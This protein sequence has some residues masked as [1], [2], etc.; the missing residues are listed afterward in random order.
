MQQV[1]VTG[2]TGFV[3]SHC[4]L[5]LLQQ[6]YA[7]KTSI[8]TP[9]KKNK[10]LEMLRTGGISDFQHIQ[11]II[12]DLTADQY[13][14]DAAAGCEYVLHVASPIYLRVPKDPEEMI[15]PAVDG[16]LRVLKAARDAG[17]KRVV[18]TSNFGAV[19]YSHRDPAT[20]ITEK[21]YTDPDEK[22]LSAYNKSKVMSEKAA[23]QFIREQGHGL[24]FCTVN[25]MGIFGPSLGPD[26]S[27]GFELLRNIINGEMKA[28]PNMDLGIVDVRD[29]ADLHIRAMTS[30]KANGERFLA[31]AGGTMSL[32]E[33]AGFIKKHL[34]AIGA[35]ISTKSLADWKVKLAAL[36]G[37]QK[38]KAVAPLLGVNRRAS[39]EKAISVLG[40]TPR[41]NETAILASVESLIKY[42]A[43]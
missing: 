41:S 18:M 14:L 22:G 34:P 27:S 25:P 11:F 24:E 1:L 12:A 42:G 40:W 16:T 37:N 35:K 3:A 15:R 5:Q 36:L 6:G 4:I 32:L 20:L 29:V 10:V 33:I 38:A 28:I 13:W 39:N 19:G 23:W 17:V 9:D 2:G 26:L 7:V 21:D 30:P 31:L 43:V 8:R